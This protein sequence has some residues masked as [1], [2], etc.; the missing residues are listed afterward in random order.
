VRHPLRFGVATNAAMS[1]PQLKQRAR[2]L[3]ELGYHSLLF[4]DHYLGPGPAISAAQHPPQNIAA[5]PAAAIAADATSTLVVGFRMLCVDYHHPVVLAKELATLDLLGNG[6]LE[7]G[8]GA[9]WMASEYSAMGIP[10]DSPGTR[11]ARLGE[12]LE[13]L[14]QFFGDGAVDFSGTFYRAHGFEGTPSPVRRPRPPI[15]VGGG[16]RKVLSL[17]ARH[18]DIISINLDMRAGT[19]GAETIGRSTCD[20]VTEKLSWISESAGERYEELVLEIGAHFAAVTDAAD[21]V[22]ETMTK[23]PT[24]IAREHPHALVGTVEQICDLIEERRERHGFSYITIQERVAEE[25]APV[26]ARLAGT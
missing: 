17:A 12:A 3:E 5:I 4:Q 6:R 19:F 23:L 8:L 22:L 1:A 14:A 18:A 25:F 2:R 21:V 15:A 13:L 16:G 24:S 26:V 10:F 20:A 9:G 11:I 7:V